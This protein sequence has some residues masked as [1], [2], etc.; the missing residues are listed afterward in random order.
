MLPRW[1]WTRFRGLVTIN[2]SDST[3][4]ARWRGAARSWT[5]SSAVV[6]A[7]TMTAHVGGAAI[8]EATV[9]SADGL[10]QCFQTSARTA[11]D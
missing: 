6:F 2:N 10:T 7:S 4:V 8:I 11:W 9:T 3:E 1:N 5:S